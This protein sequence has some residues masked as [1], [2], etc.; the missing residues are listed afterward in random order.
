M[1]RGRKKA[2][3]SSLTE[4]L[5]PIMDTL[6]RPP[7]E[8]YGPRT[9]NIARSHPAVKG[10]FTISGLSTTPETAHRGPDPGPRGARER[11]ARSATQSGGEAAHT[12]HALPGAPSGGGRA[13]GG[14]GERH[15]KQRGGEKMARPKV[16][17]CK[18]CPHLKDYRRDWG[19]CWRNVYGSW[20]CGY[21]DK[22]ITGQEVRTSPVWCPLR[23]GRRI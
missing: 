7:K 14:R 19:P 12:G 17:H 4:Q 15:D 16:P 13:G 22:H 10:W 5:L 20:R 2:A 18:E 6:R 9:T 3:P 8:R 1:E 11:G 21:V 23:Y